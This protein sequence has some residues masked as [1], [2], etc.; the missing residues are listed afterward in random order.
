MK[1]AIDARP[2]VSGDSVRGI[3]VYTR[4]LVDAFKKSKKE[5]SVLDHNFDNIEISKFDLIHFTSFNP[6]IISV[7]FIKP[8]NTKFVLTIYDLIPLIYPAHYPSGIRGGI[9]WTL[10][11]FL[12]KKNIDAILTISETSKKDICR[13]LGVDPDIVHVVYLAPRPVFRKLDTGK[14]CITPCGKSEIKKKYNLPDRFALYVGDVNYNKNIP[15][16][17]KA[18]VLAKLPLVI[19]GKQAKEIENLD[20]NHPELKH[21]KNIDWTGVIRLGFVPDIDLAAIYNLAYV[22][23]Q[24]S[25]Y[26]GFGLGVLEAIACG[27]PVVASK[28]QA[29]VEIAEGAATFVNPDNSEDMAI[30][31]KNLAKSPKLPRTYSWEKT[32]KETWEVYQNV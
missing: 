10:N 9:R 25:F 15:G 31:L 28:T 14:D 29:L 23:V 20:L 26:E 27:T 3:G 13:F 8:K 1:I 19:A 2:L 32:A 12:I 7:P 11:K 22:F 16:L 17:V 5:F 30:G 24:P 18:C 6:Y 4:E 21:L